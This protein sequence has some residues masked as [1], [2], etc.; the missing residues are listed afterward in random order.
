MSLIIAYLVLIVTGTFISY[1]IGYAIEVASSPGVSLL[2]FLTLYF[3]SLGA[4]WFIAVR[5]TAP[6]AKLA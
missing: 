5:L 2:V 3:F 1:G 4:S 6:K